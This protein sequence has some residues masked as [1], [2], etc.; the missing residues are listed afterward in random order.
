LNITA[1]LIYLSAEKFN[2]L[3]RVVRI[4]EKC[5][6]LVNNMLMD[7]KDVA[8]KNVEEDIKE[9]KIDVKKLVSI[10]P[11]PSSLFSKQRQGVK[12]KRLRLKY[13]SNAKEGEARIS[14][15]L[16]KELG[17]KDYVEVTVAGKKRFRLK[18]IIVEDL[19][20]YHIGVN[21]DQMRQLGISDNSICT[22]RPV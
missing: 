9:E 1:N 15:V 19:D 4:F 6:I 20:A 12:E 2:N 11:P 13:D 7:S 5:P 8:E 14:I 10:V 3:R 21:H 22:I 16:A 17:V 18:A